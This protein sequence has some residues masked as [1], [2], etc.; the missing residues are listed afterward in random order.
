MHLVIAGGSGFIG[1]AL[2]RT[3]ID[4]GHRVTVLSRDPQ[5]AQAAL[6]V[7]TAVVGWDGRTLAVWHRRLDDADAI[8]NL[9]GE[10]VAD[11]RWTTRRKQA[12]RDSRIGTTRLLVQAL[13]QIHR[14]PMTLIVASGV[15][16]YGPR[17][18]T[19]LTED[20]P[21]GSDFLA[22]LSYDAEQEAKQAERHGV[23]VVLFRIGI[24]L[25]SEGGALPRLVLPFRFFLGGPVAPGTQWMSWIHREDLVGLLQWVLGH[26]SLHGPVNAVAPESVTMRAFSATVGRVLGRPSWLPVPELVLRV[27][28][29]ELATLLTTG[30]RVQPQV[31]LRLG[32]HFRYPHLTEALQDILSRESV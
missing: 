29:G 4:S 17:N 27:A 2:C 3:L 22:R 19:P 16:Y 1:R 9:S 12:L 23:R 18:S 11:K 13:S 20:S 31:A 28:L 14:R 21:P 6:P 7:G 15:G 5:R 8:I 25:G 26:P 30:Q 10:P 24:V 32:Y